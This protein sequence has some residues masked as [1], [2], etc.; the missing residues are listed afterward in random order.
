LLFVGQNDAGRAV[1]RAYDKD[2]GEVIHELDVPSP[3]VYGTPVTYSVDGKQ[4][5]SIAIGGGV[6]GE[7]VTY[8]LP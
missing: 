6:R 2:T 4:Y 1:L 3:V 8:A 7:L 5:L